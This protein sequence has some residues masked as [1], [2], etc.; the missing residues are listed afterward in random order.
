MGVSKNKRTIAIG[1]KLKQL[2][3]DNG[4]TSY[5]NFAMDHDINRMYYWGAEKGRNLSLKYL[6]KILKIH[7]LTLHEFF[8]DLDV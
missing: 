4:Y 1:E 6:I 2:R 3:K 5:E 7:N 8:K